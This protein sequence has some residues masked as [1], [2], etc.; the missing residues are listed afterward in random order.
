M[1]GPGEFIEIVWYNRNIITKRTI[2]ASSAFMFPFSFS[3]CNLRNPASL[4]KI[5]Y[6][7]LK[8]II[9]LNYQTHG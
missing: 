8:V 2:K 3:I 7:F 6:I 5:I 1:Y 4:T 9:F